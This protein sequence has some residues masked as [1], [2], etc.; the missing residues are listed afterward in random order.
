MIRSSIISVLGALLLLLTAAAAI[1]FVE[2][3]TLPG[4]APAAGFADW[5]SLMVQGDFGLSSAAAG[6]VAPMIAAALSVTLPLVALAAILA[7]ALGGGLGWLAGRRDGVLQR[8]L[9]GAWQIL[10][11]APGFWIGLLLAS[12]FGA[13]LH[14]LPTGG[15]VPWSS[16]WAAATRS[17]LL[18]ALALALPAGAR[19]ALAVQHSVRTARGTRPVLAARARGASDDVAF[20][21]HAQR[22]A[23]LGAAP[24]LVDMLAFL[25]AAAVVVESAFYLPGLGR[26][27]VDGVVARNAPLAGGALLVLVTLTLATGLVARLA[28]M[29]LDPLR[30]R[31]SR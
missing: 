11:I 10:A 25:F 29:G 16:D 17:L 28:T 5:L 8:A 9:G 18:P 14:W 15:F 31:S 26:L 30:R 1:Y 3:A 6:P 24:A 22:A 27:I 4:S 12:V 2:V 7:V 19:L 21:L 23:L 13:A 20:A